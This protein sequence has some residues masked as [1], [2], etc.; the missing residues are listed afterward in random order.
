[1]Q[2]LGA[3]VIRVYH[4]DAKADH[5]GCMSEFAAAGIYTLID[6]D[7][8]DTYILP[9][10]AWWNQTQ[11]DRFAAVMDAFAS[12][13]NALGF[14]VGNEIIAASNQSTAAPFIKAAAR[15]M[16]AHRDAMKYRRFPVGYSAA[17]IAELR[18]MLQDYL[19][20]GGN[21]SENIDFFALNSYEWCGPNTFQG[22]GYA[23]LQNMS[24]NFPVP[25]F[26]SETGCITAPPRTFADQA[27]IFG[28]Q[29]VQDWSG[30]PDLRVDPGGQPV[31]PRLVWP[32]RQPRRRARQRRRRRLHPHRPA[33]PHHP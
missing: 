33:H 21:A 1:M 15:D 14:F 11:R 32:A 27:A 16:K 31:R 20:C 9:N 22:S 13:D 5:S 25:I 23:N 28:P 24:Q 10:D 19:T 7:T 29:M 12:F 30:A 2:S 26:F 4:V 3:N 8:F 6:L 18:P 17:D